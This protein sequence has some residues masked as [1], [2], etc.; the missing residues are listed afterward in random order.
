MREGGVFSWRFVAVVS[1]IACIAIEVLFNLLPIDYNTVLLF[2]FFPVSLL[3]FSQ[4]YSSKGFTKHVEV[5]LLLAFLIWGIVTVV[6]NHSRAH[7]VDSYLWFAGAC[8][9]TF[10]CF[11]IGYAFGQEQAKR[12]LMWIITT[13]LI[14]AV[15]LSLA[16][17]IAV[18]AKDFAAKFP[19]IFEDIDIAGGRLGIDAHPNRSSPAPALGIILAGILFAD[20][21]SVWKRVLLILTAIV[22]Y[23][24]LAQ[25]VSRTAILGA[26]IA[27]AFEIILALRDALKGR[28]NVILRWGICVVAAAAVVLVF[29]KGANWTVQTCN[30]ILAQEA[31]AQT[32]AEPAALPETASQPALEATSEPQA[33]AQAQTPEATAAVISRDLSDADSFNGRTDIWLGVWN[34]IKQ[35][36]SIFAIGTGPWVASKV[37]AP[38]FPVNSPIG[39][40]HNSMVGTLVAFGIPGLILAIAF[41]V[42]VAVSALRFS[43]GKKQ[44]QPLAVR[45]LPGILLFAV[46]EGM[47]ED[48][49]FAVNSLNIVWIWFLIAAG[50]IFRLSKPNQAQKPE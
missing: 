16:S 30:A 7:M 10:L 38:Y 37:M 25:T 47:M 44:V 11:G 2:W 28:L 9:V 26:G 48:F 4:L 23:I 41:L 42:L 36:P 35:N 29:Y 31:S 49:L 14:S 3:L 24:P 50:F 33:P 18:F 27:I 45:M 5:K 8:T 1:L 19:S 43:F 15:L 12:V 32:A 20:T 21:K 17:L 13:M 6:L 40:F 34:G 46:A 39:I 22:C